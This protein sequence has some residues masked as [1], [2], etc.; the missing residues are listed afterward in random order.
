M[1]GCRSETASTHTQKALWSGGGSYII[2]AAGQRPSLLD[3]RKWHQ[4]GPS[5]FVKTRRDIQIYRYT[6]LQI[7]ITVTSN[8]VEDDDDQEEVDVDRYC[9]RA[10]VCACV[11]V[12]ACMCG[13]GFISVSVEIKRQ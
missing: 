8:N 2:W 11:R 13:A 7:Y 1:T 10:C 4:E 5:S 9:V 6:D 12:C 3:K